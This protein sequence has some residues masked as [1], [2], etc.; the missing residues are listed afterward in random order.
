MKKIIPSGRTRKHK[1]KRRGRHGTRV[2]ENTSWYVAPLGR[3]F[4]DDKTSRITKSGVG[5]QLDV[6]LSRRG[7]LYMDLFW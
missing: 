7:Q 3:N 6:G 4:A 5:G 1:K 2:E